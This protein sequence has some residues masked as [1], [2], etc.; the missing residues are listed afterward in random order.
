MRLKRFLMIVVLGGLLMTSSLSLVGCGG[1]SDE[2]I[3]QHK[4]LVAEVN[5]LENEIKSLREQKAALERQV[6]EINAK[7][8][9]CAKDKEATK[10][11]LEKLPK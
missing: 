7:L 9:K 6:G 5:S 10:K 4:A 3:A 2:Q 8:E 1:L 11:N